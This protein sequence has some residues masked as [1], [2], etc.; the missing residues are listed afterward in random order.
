MELVDRHTAGRE[1]LVEVEQER[2]PTARKEARQVGEQVVQGRTSVDPMVSLLS[3]TMAL[4][5]APHFLSFRCPIRQ[6]F[7]R[8][9]HDRG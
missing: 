5:D 8:P 1:A 2:L 7:L 6:G 9:R 4:Y 3:T